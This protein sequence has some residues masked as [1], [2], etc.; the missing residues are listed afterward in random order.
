MTIRQVI[1]CFALLFSAHKVC[2]Q[3]HANNWYFG[4]NA[5]ITFNSGTP[6]ALLDGL[7]V[8]NEGC[9]SFSDE[10]GGLIFYTDGINVWNRNH[11]AMPNGCRRKRLWV[12]LF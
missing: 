11:Q 1:Y 8:T 6:T 5:G 12:L 10:N 2:G 3:G 9:T 4:Q 7:L